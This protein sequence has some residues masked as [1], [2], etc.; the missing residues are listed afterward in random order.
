MEI[1]SPLSLPHLRGTVLAVDM[2][3]ACVRRDQADHHGLVIEVDAAARR[4]DDPAGGLPLYL[5]A[6]HAVEELLADA[7][8]I[9]GCTPGSTAILAE[10]SVAAEAEDLIQHFPMPL[11]FA[12]LLRDFATGDLT[13]FSALSGAD[14]I[15][16]VSLATAAAMQTASPS[17]PPPWKS[18]TESVRR[19]PVRAESVFCI[20]RI[21]DAGC[22]SDRRSGC[23]SLLRFPHS[24]E[25]SRFRSSGPGALVF[26]C[27]SL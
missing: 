8:E 15:A 7:L 16:A 26:C 9:L 17:R 23:L 22:V 19:R 5:A 3:R 27:C 10:T 14:R 12:A 1:F 4:L 2:V 21:W 25:P 18:W 6:E 13:P 20:S 11:Q 24:V